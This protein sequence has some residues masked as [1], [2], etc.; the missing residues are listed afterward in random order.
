MWYDGAAEIFTVLLYI[1]QAKMEEPKARNRLFSFS[2]LKTKNFSKKHKKTLDISGGCAII[3]K[4]SDRDTQNQN[5]IW[6]YS[7]AGSVDS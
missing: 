5:K 6:G 3:Q 2:L 1:I 7:S 4:L